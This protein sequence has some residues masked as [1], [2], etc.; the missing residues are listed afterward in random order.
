MKDLKTLQSLPLECKIGKTQAKILEFGTH[1]N[2]KIYISF[3]GGKDSTVLLDLARRIYPDIPAVFCD[4]GLEYPEVRD[5]VKTIDNVIWIKPEVSFKDVI[6]TYGYPVIGKEVALMIRSA[7]NSKQWA[8]N[9]L[10]GLNKDGTPSKFK[11]KRFPKFEY[12]MEAPFLISDRCCDEIKEKPFEKFQRR[13]KL[14]PIIG[15]TARESMRRQQAWLM[16]GCN[17]FAKGGKSKPLS[18][19][20]EQDILQ[21]LKKYCRLGYCNIYGDIIEVDD[22]GKRK[23]NNAEDRAQLRLDLSGVAGIEIKPPPPPPPRLSLTGLKRTGCMFCA[24]GISQDGNPNRF[25]RM[26]LTHPRLY[27]YCINKLGCGKVLDYIGM[28]Y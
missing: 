10:K 15:I 23:N 22:T 24:F 4:T 19:W 5:F 11:E 6:E 16:T 7:R 9:A 25:Q 18:F 8:L 12:L 13:E 21:Y 27:D 20:T 2:G 1:H 14:H 26:K 17:S 3:S 28:K